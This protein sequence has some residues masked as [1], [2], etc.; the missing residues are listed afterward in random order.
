MGQVPSMWTKFCSKSEENQKI[1]PGHH[2]YVS[3]DNL[4]QVYPKGLT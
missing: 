1:I 3:F 4:Q 2:S